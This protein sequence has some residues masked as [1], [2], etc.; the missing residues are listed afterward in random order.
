[1]VGRRSELVN[2][3]FE[4]P[5]NLLS[6]TLVDDGAN[7]VRAF[8][9]S[10][11]WVRNRWRFFFRH[12]ISGPSISFNPI[13]FVPGQE[14]EGGEPILRACG[15]IFFSGV[16]HPYSVSKRF[17][18]SQ[19]NIVT[20]LRP[21]WPYRRLDIEGGCCLVDDPDGHSKRLEQLLSNHLMAFDAVPQ[22]IKELRRIPLSMN[23]C[24]HLGISITHFVT[25]YCAPILRRRDPT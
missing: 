22:S 13:F 21:S 3:F 23:K 15:S 25:H 20:R 2:G 9:W 5:E 17:L 1:M 24:N 18:A 14:I 12:T 6:P 10:T 7:K 11:L 4:R 19:Q 8:D 16:S